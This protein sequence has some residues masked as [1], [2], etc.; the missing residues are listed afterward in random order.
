M[1]TG[2]SLASLSNA[3][4]SG[5]TTL[6]LTAALALPAAAQLELLPDSEPQ[7][8]FGGTTRQL[9][10]RWRNPG[11]SAVTVELHGRLLQASSGTVAPLGEWFW[12]KLEILPGQTVLE[13]AA[14]PLP[15]VRAE[16]RCLVQ[17]VAGT[18]RVLGATEV[19]VYPANL[20]TELRSLAGDHPVGLF[21]PQAQLKPLLERLGVEFADLELSG[22]ADFTGKL[23]IIGPFASAANM[24]PDMPARIKHAAK[25]GAA[26][27]WIQ[28]PP[29]RDEPLRPSFR[30]VAS[31]KGA[32]VVAQ[33]YI[34]ADLA[35]QP[36][37]QINLLH[38]ARLAIHPL[39][40]PI[41]E[42]SLLETL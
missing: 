8:V 31:S 23:A 14:V 30:C 3:V 5:L 27:V 24:P 7:Q 26:I 38:L 41:P 29:A 19:R 40:A 28:P 22:I 16:T 15:S 17:W 25:K 11:A 13:S 21:D 6:V 4:G 37:S 1:N 18:N 36:Q 10:V 33:S 34:V 35:D 2:R 12:K 42:P 9:A 39:P 32:I 20:L